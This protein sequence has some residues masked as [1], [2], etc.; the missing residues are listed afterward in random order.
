M[1]P[2]GESAADIF[3]EPSFQLKGIFAGVRYGRFHRIL[4]IAPTRRFDGFLRRHPKIDDVR[5]QL[6]IGLY[7]CVCSRCAADEEGFAIFC[8]NHRVHGV[9]HTLAGH[10]AIGVVCL[11]MPIRHPIVEQDAGVASDET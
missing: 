3:R 9:T 4:K 8:Y 10:E 5:D 1:P 11:K 7:L 2:L 6:E